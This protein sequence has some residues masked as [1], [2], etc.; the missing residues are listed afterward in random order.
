MTKAADAIVIG[1]GVHGASA[2]FH[3]ASLGL[4]VLVL[5]RHGV[6]AG[7]TG[8]S[9]GLIRMH[10][11]FAPDA[12][13]AW[14]SFPYFRDSDELIGAECGFRRTGF[15]QFV[16]PALHDRLRANVSVL[17]KI[18]IPTFL[19]SA[20]DIRGLAPALLTDDE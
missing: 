1:A 20:D 5:E 16:R 2:A 12:R 18:G 7:A 9:D 13:L 17:Q 8:R 14:A 3:L 11:D 6:A 4:H 19:V 10:Y 15:L